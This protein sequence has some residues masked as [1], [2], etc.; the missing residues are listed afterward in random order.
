MSEIKPKMI[1]G[2]AVCDRSCPSCEEKSNWTTVFLCSHTDQQV[3]QYVDYDDPC[4]PYYHERCAELEA[5]R[6]K[7]IELAVRFGGIDGDHHK[8][9]VIDQMVRALTGCPMVKK[10][11]KDFEGKEYEYECQ[12]ES[13]EYVELVREAK[14]GEDG[15]ETYSWNEGIAP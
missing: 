5:G 4:V 1:N 2:K 3:L 7:A 15:P 10:T 8:A 13:E 14:N 12:G 6:D 11:A 9:W